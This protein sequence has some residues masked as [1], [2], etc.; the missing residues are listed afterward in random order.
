MLGQTR[1]KILNKLGGNAKM[2]GRQGIVP[3]TAGR[4]R[5]RASGKSAFY[6]ATQA[7]RS[8]VFFSGP[9]KGCTRL[10]ILP[11]SNNPTACMTTLPPD[12]PDKFAKP[13]PTQPALGQFEAF[14]NQLVSQVDLETL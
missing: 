8:T 9:R 2:P 11:S 6:L 3:R 5:D 12:G 7:A 14:R 10:D 4:A 13:I 1:D